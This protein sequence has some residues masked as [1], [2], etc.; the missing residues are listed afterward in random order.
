MIESSKKILLIID[1]LGPGG[2]Q[3]QLTR[4]ALGLK[5]MGHQI[6]VFTYYP[7]HF[8]LHRLKSAG[9]AHIHK[10]KKGKFGIP[11]VRK[12]IQLLKDHSFDTVIS[13]MD[14]PNFYATMACLI[15]GSNAHLAVSYRTKTDF[16]SQPW[17]LKKLR[18]WVNKKANF[19]ICNSVHERERWSRNY[20]TLKSKIKTVY[21]IVALNSSSPAMDKKNE[22]TFLMVG[23]VRPLKNADLVAEA[24]AILRNKYK[25]E[26]RIHWYGSREFVNNTFRTYQF[27]IDEKL[28]SLGVDDLW[29]WFP[30]IESLDSIYPKY[31]GLVHASL[32]EGLPNV[33]C[34]SLASGL[35]V[36]AS[37]ILD[38]PILVKEGERGFLFDPSDPEE[39]AQKMIQFLKLSKA[40]KEK[41]SHSCKIYAADAFQE[42]RIIKQL[43][44]FVD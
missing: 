41:I 43:L 16:N 36:L 28:K 2:A 15:S 22:A 32:W 17:H 21:N 25:R 8:F 42:E 26:V 6:Y 11:V 37:N 27:E 29:E 4:L 35:P 24:I 14:T 19:I 39:L 30:P 9:I 12:L 31:V 3:N 13:F 20:P 38:H 10:K 23:K 7:N 1:S 33:V 34:E 40:D 18:E 44:E 5:K